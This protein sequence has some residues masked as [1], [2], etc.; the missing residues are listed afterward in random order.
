M[1]DITSLS[2]GLLAIYIAKR[3]G[4]K[5]RIRWVKFQS[6]LTNQISQS[7]KQMADTKPRKKQEKGFI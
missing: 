3:L 4:N 6:F 1:Q 2:V 7:I 5:T